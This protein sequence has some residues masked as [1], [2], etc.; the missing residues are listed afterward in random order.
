M[1]LDRLSPKALI[2]ASLF[3]GLTFQLLLGTSYVGAFLDPL[4]ESSGIPVA[5]VNHDRGDAGARFLSAVAAKDTPVRWVAV[6]SRAAAIQGLETKRYHGALLL[7]EN[8]TEALT[9]LG[10]TSP[11]AA[12]V[13]LL[14]NPGAS[15][16]GSLTASRVMEAAL[17]GLRAEVQARAIDAATPDAP[18]AAPLPR[19]GV[20]TV[21]QA[22]VLADPVKVTTTVVNAVPP[23]GANGLAPLYLT[24]AA[25]VGGYFGAVALERFREKTRLTPGRRALVVPAGAALQGLVATA[26]LLLIGFPVPDPFLLAGVLALGAWMAYAVVSLLLDLFGLPGVAP[27]FAL[28]ALGIPASGGVYPPEML[29]P[30]F[31]AVHALDPFTW[32]LEALRTALHVPRAT[33]LAGH[34]LRL[35]AT[36]LA[37]TALS[38]AWHRLRERRARRVP[39]AAARAAAPQAE[40]EVRA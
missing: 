38:L 32:L 21:E 4:E 35:A 3:A 30:L 13:E 2:A 16:S 15:P 31:R 28:M 7:P 10:T 8:F 17:A 14:T 22:R 9:S 24:M 40:S 19:G 5:V 11:R 18:L 26:A 1:L 39:T 37:A 20:F 29:T 33:D 27:A 6:E 12:S 23:R 36:A 25:W 34:A